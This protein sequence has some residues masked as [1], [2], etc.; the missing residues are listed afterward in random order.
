MVGPRSVPRCR[1]QFLLPLYPA[2][3]A[4][5]VSLCTSPPPP[6]PSPSVPPRRR[7]LRFSLYP[8]QPLPRGSFSCGP[9]CFISLKARSN[10]TLESSYI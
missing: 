6:P 10:S 3:A 4:V 7:R 9:P 1:R 2:T 8:S 5:S